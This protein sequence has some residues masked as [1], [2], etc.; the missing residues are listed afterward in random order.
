M[1]PVLDLLPSGAVAKEPPLEGKMVEKFT[2]T[3]WHC[4]VSC[5]SLTCADTVAATER[6]AIRN[7]NL[8]T[9]YLNTAFQMM[10]GRSMF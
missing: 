5:V 7:A 2:P 1:E 4:I 9:S 8:F 3:I 10:S 6:I